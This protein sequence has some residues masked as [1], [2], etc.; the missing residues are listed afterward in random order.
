MKGVGTALW[1]YPHPS[2]YREG[3]PGGV[4]P[5]LAALFVTTVCVDMATSVRDQAGAC[6]GR[7]RP[8]PGSGGSHLGV[9]REIESYWGEGRSDGGDAVSEA[10]RPNR[11]TN[12]RRFVPAPRCG[13]SL[14]AASLDT[15]AL[16]SEAQ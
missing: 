4:V 6:D 8:S 2:G 16:Y 5:R 14:V 9:V 11:I 1:L 7:N 12:R 3:Y 15:K 13:A 10:A